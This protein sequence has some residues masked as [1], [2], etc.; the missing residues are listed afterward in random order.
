MKPLYSRGSEERLHLY[1]FPWCYAYSTTHLSDLSKHM[2]RS[3]SNRGKKCIYI[4]GYQLHVQSPV[5][6]TPC[7]IS[8]HLGNGQYCLTG[9]KNKSAVK[10]V[11]KWSLFDVANYIQVLFPSW[12]YCWGSLDTC[13]MTCQCVWALT[14]GEPLMLQLAPVFGVC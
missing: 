6:C 12:L 13:Q 7:I 10:K 5:C 1:S 9:D 4:I 14:G 11:W 3:K 2:H 8:W